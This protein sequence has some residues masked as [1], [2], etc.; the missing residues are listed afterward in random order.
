M[1]MVTRSTLEQ[2]LRHLIE[3][4]KREEKVHW[5]KADRIYEKSGMTDDHA[6]QQGAT[7]A[8]HEIIKRLERLLE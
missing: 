2:D 4:L 6:Y 8:Y 7:C 1:A 5:E 3:D